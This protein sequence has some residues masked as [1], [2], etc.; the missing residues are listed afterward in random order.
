MTTSE[1][2]LRKR[3]YVSYANRSLP[4]E[5]MMPCREKKRTRVSS[6]S[7]ADPKRGA[8]AGGGAKGDAKGKSLETG[9]KTKTICHVKTKS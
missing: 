2:M 9:G 8:G 3:R 1:Y 4:V 5:S 6:S 7:Y